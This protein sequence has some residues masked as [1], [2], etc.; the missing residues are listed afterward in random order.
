MPN[1]PIAEHTWDSEVKPVENTVI[2][3]MES[4]AQ[5]AYEISGTDWF[6]VTLE[7]V[8]NH[9]HSRA[10]G[11]NIEAFYRTNRFAENI[12]FACRG[13]YYT[14]L[15]TAP[16]EIVQLRGFGRWRITCQFRATRG[17]KV[18]AVPT[19]G[20]STNYL[21]LYLQHRGNL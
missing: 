12:V 20:T 6:S 5:H 4:G 1:F 18:P 10:I 14:G 16:P 7:T 13:F 15:F 8:I 11:D 17:G 2:D 19:I 21:A 3:T 9:D